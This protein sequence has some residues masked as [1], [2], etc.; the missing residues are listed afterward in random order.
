MTTKKKR[1]KKTGTPC[2]KCLLNLDQEKKN[3]STTHL[4]Y[5]KESDKS[6][7]LINE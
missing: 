3:I 5:Y 4:V 6:G 1:R 2:D 7:A